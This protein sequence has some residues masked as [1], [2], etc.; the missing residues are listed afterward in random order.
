MYHGKFN[1]NLSTEEGS[2]FVLYVSFA[3]LRSLKPQHLLIP[4]ES[5]DKYG[6][7]QLVS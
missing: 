7:T 4:L 3:T 2:L 6:C 5:P 1:T